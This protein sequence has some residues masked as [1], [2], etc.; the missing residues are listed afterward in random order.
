[1]RPPLLRTNRLEAIP[2]DL[3]DGKDASGACET[4]TLNDSELVRA[5]GWAV[6]NAKGRPPDSVVIAYENPAGDGWVA[7]AMSDSFEMRAEIVKRFHSMDQLW[8]GWSA[9]FPRT[10]FP[11]GAKLSFWALDADE[12]KLYRLKDNAMPTIR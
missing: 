12:P 3:A 6:L 5:R 1:M 10:A 4:I 9:T 11:A 7:C 8:S 2:H